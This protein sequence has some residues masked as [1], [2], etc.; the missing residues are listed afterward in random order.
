[1]MKKAIPAFAAALMTLGVMVPAHADDQYHDRDHQHHPVCHK[2][3][4]HG[5]WEKRCY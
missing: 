1:M 3:H 2:V 4:V 5:H